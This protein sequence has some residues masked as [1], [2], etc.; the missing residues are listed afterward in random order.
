M[1]AR[2]AFHVT[3]VVE[4]LATAHCTLEV[5]LFECI[6]A[7]LDEVVDEVFSPRVTK[8]AVEGTVSYICVFVNRHFNI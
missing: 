4:K 1:V 2:V 8:T 7:R 5:E 3:D 6:F